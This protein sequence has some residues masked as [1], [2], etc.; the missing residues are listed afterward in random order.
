M[1]SLLICI[2][3]LS[4]GVARGQE[5]MGLDSIVAEIGRSHP[6]LRSSDAL[7]RSLDEGA[8][9]ARSWDAPQ[10]S[11]GW[12]MTPYDPS[13]WKQQGQYMVSA[14]QMFPNRR[15]QEAEEAYLQGMSAVERAK[16][17][18]TANELYAAAGRA[19]DQWVVAV[20]RMGVLDEDAKLLDFMIRDA[21]LRYKNNLG[22]I[23]AYYKAKAAL[24][25]LED[26][27]IGLEN[28]VEQARI[29]L[30]TLMNRDKGTVFEVDT[31][32]TP[33]GP[34]VP[35]DSA[36][37]LAT[38][39]DIRA[40]NES[41]RL[42]GL[43]AAAE[44]SK[45]RPEF[46]LR[47]DHMFSFGGMPMEYTLMATVRLPMASWSSRGTKANVERLKWQTESLEEEREAMVNEAT[48]A[49]YG[50]QRALDAKRRQVEVLKEQV[51]PA[52]RKNFETLEL[53]YEQNTEELL[54]V[55]DAWDTL[56]STQLEY[57]DDVEQLLLMEVELK[58]VL[59]LK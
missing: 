22:K 13:L 27:R 36:G 16:K 23:G 55:Y 12:W 37:L 48:G 24:G 29:V 7:A 40:V 8:K 58:R 41:I 49:A 18:T 42:N 14:E 30:N 32:V 35:V 9:G 43:E 51:L 15:T 50:L 17:G 28:T 19:Y 20:H 34:V 5:A 6:S 1:K 10:V 44:R 38:R 4:A 57:W 26:R 31:A 45:L 11:T 33:L 3:L 53:A 59:E 52:L 56:D 47:Y 54:S 2:G 46:G 21:E 25:R 39:S